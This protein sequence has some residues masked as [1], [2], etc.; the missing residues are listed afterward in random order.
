M[1]ADQVPI[2]GV[3]LARRVPHA[4]VLVVALP[5]IAA[6]LVKLAILLAFDAIQRA[7]S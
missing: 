3:A 1:L 5:A 2:P 6:I 4:V 7:V